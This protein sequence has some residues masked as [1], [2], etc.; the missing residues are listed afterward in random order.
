M[1]RPASKSDLITAA[2]GNYKEMNA[3]I[4]SMTEK[5]LAT[6]FSFDDSK[7]RKQTLSPQTL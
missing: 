4:A 6:P 5:E 7:R 2:N 1:G 3:F